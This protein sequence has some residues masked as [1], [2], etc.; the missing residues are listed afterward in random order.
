M[1]KCENCGNTITNESNYCRFCGTRFGLRPQAPQQQPNYTY[2]PP[3]PYAW[4]TD[5][6]QTQAEARQQP[7]APIQ[8]FDAS[9]LAP[10]RFSCPNCGNTFPP[11]IE[12]RISTA[13]WIV[14]AILLVV[15]FPLFWIGLLIREDVKVCS[16]CSARTA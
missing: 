13:G 5:E 15:F 16:V 9:Y 6:F 4:K 3:R 14:F 7:S 2:A 1:I 8:H 10:S 12:R 11:R